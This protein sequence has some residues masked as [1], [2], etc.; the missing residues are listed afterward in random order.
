MLNY[1][2]VI[3]ALIAPAFCSLCQAVEKGRFQLRRN[4]AGSVRVK[5]GEN[6]AVNGQ[7]YD[8][9]SPVIAQVANGD[10]AVCLVGTDILPRGNDWRA[11]CTFTAKRKTAR[12][13]N[14]MLTLVPVNV[15]F[16]EER[17][18]LNISV[19]C[20]LSKSGEPIGWAHGQR[21]KI[22]K[23]NFSPKIHAG[24][25][26]R[27]SF[28]IVH[29]ANEKILRISFS[30]GLKT[31]SCTIKTNTI[32]DTPRP[33]FLALGTPNTAYCR[34]G[35][36]I[37]HSAKY[38]A[39]LR[40]KEQRFRPKNPPVIVPAPQEITWEKSWF[41]I[42]RTISLTGSELLKQ[43][44]AEKCDTKTDV[45]A[46]AKI[47][48]TDFSVPSELV[49]VCCDNNI[50]PPEN[51]EGYTIKVSPNKIFIAGRTSRGTYYG[52]QTL[53]QMIQK[54]KKNQWG[55]RCSTVRDWPDFPIRMA[56]CPWNEVFT[57][58]RQVNEEAV[59]AFSEKK[60]NA[61]VFESNNWFEIENPQKL[62]MLKQWAAVLRK[63]Y[64]DVVAFST[65]LGHADAAIRK[66]PVVAEGYWVRKEQ[67]VFTSDKLTIALEHKNVIQT[68]TTHI[69]ITGKDGKVFKA[70]IDYKIIKGELK[71]YS[72]PE[73]VK[74]F[75][76]QRCVGSSIPLNEPVYVSYDYIPFR[77]QSKHDLCSCPS[78]PQFYTMQDRIFGII[79]KE[80]KPK[81]FLINRDEPVQMSTDSRCL[82]SG[83]T[84]AELFASDIR[85]TVASIWSYDPKV[86][87]MMWADALTPSRGGLE[88]TK[89]PTYPA[90]DLI[91]KGVI[92][93]PWYYDFERTFARNDID[94]LTR[95]GFRIIGG[96]SRKSGNPKW[97]AD[98]AYQSKEKG[99][100]GL[101]CTP[102]VG[103]KNTY[104]EFAEYAWTHSKPT[105]FDYDKFNKSKPGW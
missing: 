34:S 14:L 15:D 17:S 26:G 20:T 47:I 57:K 54:P 46:S 43:K 91:P 56:Y 72:S 45:T 78:E 96:C 79:I 69:E 53:L 94:Y 36:W 71:P 31:S 60:I 67:I 89:N 16:F 65:G 8:G 80:L 102:W 51:P 7:D 10:G 66:N 12:N 1:R 92:L 95:K 104:W 62:R 74:P 3:T 76:I 83:K 13:F 68:K 4:G 82:R 61:M 19:H 52:L 75:Q 100:L 103:R 28:R 21:H 98:L 44:L 93:L 42:P 5:I 63:Y 9:K 105:Q 77:S 84:N 85:R 87:V 24:Y 86:K 33:W 35:D 11:S 90:V 70:N 18:W 55:I 59:R 58:S 37:I 99:T 29:D 81:Y 2:I 30:N 23:L 48:V 88:I 40:L 32:R 50:F 73:K 6:W 97:W 101:I 27:D 39:P 25:R 41:I 64:I 49:K 38:D 22:I